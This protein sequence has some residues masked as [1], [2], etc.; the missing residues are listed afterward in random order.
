V[1][2]AEP[3]SRLAGVYDEL[4]VDPCHPH[5]AAHLNEL[6]G[7]D[8]AGVRTV[9]DVCCGTGLMAAELVTL[10][11]DVVGVDASPAM[12]ARARN[13]LGPGVSLFQQTLPDLRVDRVFDAAISNFDALNYLSPTDLTPTLAAVA[14]RLRP[15]GW[16]VFDL[17][18]DTMMGFT[19]A[20]PVVDGADHRHTFSIASAV[21]IQTRTCDTRIEITRTDDGDTFIEEHRQYFFSD[22]QVR[23]ALTDAGFEKIRTTD[24]YSNAPVD[25][26]TLRATW[27]ARRATA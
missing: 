15:G 26:A 27:T 18:T 24:E 2:A 9:L 8:D 16:L 17:H 3:Y 20:H 1:N 22:A 12:L 13:L 5:W 19:V 23:A 7:S 21:D 10:G 25:D 11:Y 4:V 6:W 14:D